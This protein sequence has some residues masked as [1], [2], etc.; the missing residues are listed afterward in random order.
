MQ[1]ENKLVEMV[2]AKGIIPYS[3]MN[4]YELEGKLIES[5]TDGKINTEG[6]DGNV[7][8]YVV[9]TR[10]GYI[11][12]GNNYVVDA[13][14]QKIEGSGELAIE[15]VKVSQQKLKEATERYNAKKKEYFETVIN[16]FK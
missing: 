13:N 10:D 12:Y 3:Q 9:L 1:I 15:L 5:F 14:R 7:D 2:E 6:A 16:S 11:A 4:I 8:R